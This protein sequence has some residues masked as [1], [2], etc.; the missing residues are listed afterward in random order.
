MAKENDDSTSARAIIA[1]CVATVGVC[2]LV[3]S[4]SAA[5]SLAPLP[6]SLPTAQNRTQASATLI[7]TPTIIPVP[8]LTSTP[9]TDRITQQELMAVYKD[10]VEANAQAIEAAHNTLNLILVLAA[11]V[12]GILTATGIRA[13]L[14]AREADRLAKEAHRVTA[15]VS[16][17]VSGSLKELESREAQ[18]QQRLEELLLLV[19]QS[20]DKLQELERSS[21]GLLRTLGEQREQIESDSQIL[22]RLHALAEVDRYAMELFGDD[23]IHR[24][25]AKKGLLQLSRN[26]VPVIRRECL[27]VFAVMPDYLDDWLDKEVLARIVDLMNKDEERGVRKEAEAAKDI[28]E[29]RGGE[30]YKKLMGSARDIGTGA[31]GT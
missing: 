21:E 14:S 26:C 22:E 7:L 17:R 30:K 15:E 9:D 23:P 6:A 24:K 13:V 3:S 10:L 31:V 8:T 27:Q 18:I 4:V 28:W 19:N 16:N 1:L 20:Q 12:G 11:L 2:V 25:A 5:F 29:S